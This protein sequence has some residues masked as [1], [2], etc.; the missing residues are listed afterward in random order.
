MSSVDLSIDSEEFA[1]QRTFLY[2]LT[3]RNDVPNEVKALLEKIEIALANGA[4][5]K[6]IFLAAKEDQ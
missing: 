4:D 2:A 3:V 5:V 1:M 6:S